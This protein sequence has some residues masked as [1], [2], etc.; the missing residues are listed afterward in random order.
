MV[1]SDL[2]IFLKRHW[3]LLAG[4]GLIICGVALRLALTLIGWPHTNSE[5]GTMGLEAMHILLRGEHPVYFY[6]QNYMGTGEAYI[7]A[8]SFRIFGISIVSLRLGMILLYAIFMASVFWMAHLLYSR[9]VALASLGVLIFGT[10]FLVQIELIADG[11]KAETM[12][13]GA[14][15]FALAS[16][17]ALS[18]PNRE[19]PRRQRLLRSVAFLTWGV[20]AGLG[21]YTYA[22]IAPFVLTSG[23]LLWITCR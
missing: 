9:R 22:I 14:L 3:Y 10:P 4:Y 11:G 20:I 13:F 8:I 5:E 15:M 12:A 2:P 6:G 1:L 16:W 17:L 7:G 23:V 18:R 19:T 21:L